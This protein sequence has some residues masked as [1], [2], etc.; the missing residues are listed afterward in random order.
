MDLNPKPVSIIL[1]IFFLILT[2]A[3]LTLS[4]SQDKSPV[5]YQKISEITAKIEQEIINIRRDI[6]AHPELAFQEKRTSAIVAA[7]FQKLGLEVRTGLAGTGVLG[8]LRGGRPGPVLAVRGD[9]DALAITEETDLPFASKEKINLDGKETGLMHACGHDIHTSILLGVATVLSRMKNQVPGTL[10]FIAQ[11]AEEWGDGA[12]KMLQDGVFKDYKPEAAFAF[13]VDDTSKVGYVKYISGY[14]GANVDTFSLTINSQGCHGAHPNLCVDPVVAGAQVVLA[15]QV[16]ASREIDVHD[17]AVITVGYFHAGTATNIIP[18]KAE[19]RATIRSY[20]DKQRNLLKEKITRTITNICEAYG[21]PFKLDYQFGTPALYNHS[22]L[23]K[24]VLPTVEK[25]LGGK[26]YV[27]EDRP[28]MGGEDFS[29][30]AREI[31]AVMLDLG[32]VPSHL[33]KTAVHSPTFIADERALAVGIKLMSCILM[34]YAHKPI[35]LQKPSLSQN[36]F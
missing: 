19:L 21:A 12:Q 5:Y 3:R 32:V 34:D 8:I 11:P 26:D 22:E 23:L 29:Y 30:F 18:Q 10:L 6:H 33:E 2:S 4:E 31:P 14:A 20:G 25:V 36:D 1:L 35:R 17:D 27:I 13:H 28:S 9:M 7:H 24:A 15:L 16:M